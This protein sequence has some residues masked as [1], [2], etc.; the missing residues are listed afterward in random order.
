MG[1]VDIFSKRQR[2]MRGEFSDVYQYEDL[3]IGFR[4]QS[5]LILDDVFTPKNESPYHQKNL[6]SRYFKTIH[7]LL[8]RELELFQLTEGE[9]DPWKGVVSFFLNTTSVED[10]LSVIETSL[11]SAEALQQQERFLSF[12]MTVNDAVKELNTR[13]MEHRIGY[14]FESNEIVRIESKFLHQEAV[15]PALQLLQA[16][17]YAGANGEFRKAHEHYRKQRYSEA[18]NECLKALESTLKIICKKRKWVFDDKKDTAHKLL[19]IVFEEELV[20]T[21]LQTQ[22]ASLRSV[23]ESGVPTIRNRESGHGA[24]EEPR[25][26]PQHLAAYVLHLTASAIVFISQ[27]DDE[28]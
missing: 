18:V 24:G 14:Q 20:P 16:K 9:N 4:R 27:C 25:H 12:K 5:V 1:I 15:K 21:Y 10:A 17:R 8:A 3:P 6:R 22:F 28:L 23:L 13:F 7:N 2:R 11:I 19:Q 26:I